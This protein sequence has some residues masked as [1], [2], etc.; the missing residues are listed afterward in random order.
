MT[1]R[2]VPHTSQ[3]ALRILVTGADGQ[4]GQSLRLLSQ[5]HPA[6]A[7]YAF[8]SRAQLDITR[9][10]SIAA[11]LD[12]HPTDILINAA[13]Y[14]AVDRAATEPEL[15]HAVNA[16]APGLLAKACAARGTRLLHVSTDYVFD[17]HLARPYRE[18][19][20]TAPLNT[21]GHS[22]LAGEQAVLQSDPNA[23]IVRTS[24]VFSAWGGNFVRTM[25]RLGAQRDSLQVIDDQ[26]GGPTWA[27][28][29][30]Q[31]LLD[32]ALRPA[33]TVPGGL[34]HFGG[35]PWISWHGFALE[36]LNRAHTRGL[37][38][39][40]PRVEA[41]SAANWPS[42]EPRPANGR[43]DGTRLARVLGPVAQ[44]W[45]IGLDHVLDTWASSGV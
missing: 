26:V 45:R 7:R 16:Q 22:K 11:W 23:V 3:P 43:L 36:I 41:I 9:A 32:L 42:P 40:I 17:G 33:S 25:V 29:L 38:A 8:L 12:A 30:A 28:H 5:Q 2:T 15:A 34:Y 14:T 37:I 10:E 1:Y 39:R 6:S 27:G 4:L 24:W 13:A 19:D 31:I 35:Q 44:D 21:Y 18:D 20:A